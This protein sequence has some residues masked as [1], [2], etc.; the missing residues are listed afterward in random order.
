MS[1]KF[2]VIVP[3]RERADT[4]FGC[5]KNLLQQDY[6]NFEIL[7]SDNFSQDKTYDLVSSFSSPII[8]YINTGKRISMAHNWEFA[9]RQVDSG[10]V[11]FIG[12]DDG[13]IQ[14][15]LI[16]LNDVINSTSCDALTATSC[17]FW[18]PKHFLSKPDGELTIPLPVKNLYEIR[19]SARM[20]DLVMRG[21]IPYSELPWLYHGGAAS[22][23]LLNKL[24]GADGNFFQ[25]I[26]PDIYSAIS[27]ALGTQTYVKVDTPI[28]I[29]GASK[30]SGGVSY[31][32]GN[33]DEITS[34]S[35]KFLG[36][37]N[38]PFDSRLILGKSLQL[39]VF[40]CYLKAN[41]LY[42]IANYSLINQLKIALISAPSNYFQTLLVDCKLMATSNNIPFPRISVIVFFRLIFRI[43]FIFRSIFKRPAITVSATKLGAWDIH[44]AAISAKNIYVFLQ[45]FVCNGSLY[46]KSGFI[47]IFV[48]LNFLNKYRKKI[49]DRTK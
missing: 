8:R 24:R 36:E 1:I 40:E 25:S 9:L 42:K 32:Q 13:L 29:N 22:V 16:T 23:D 14:G 15:S 48:Y 7:V 47:I 21:E 26:N 19:S 18:W 6:D 44:L 20:L 41:H 27:L 2:T 4:L 31:M 11:M 10:W 5:I 3:T 12:D 45:A 39:F 34:P 17:D 49:E 38:I 43:K 35:S 37:S 46:V 33:K 30:F 28:A